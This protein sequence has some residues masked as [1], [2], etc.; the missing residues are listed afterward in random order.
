MS[1]SPI[2][3]SALILLTVSC[4]NISKQKTPIQQTQS[5]DSEYREWSGPGLYWGIYINNEDDYWNH[6][7][8]HYNQER[9]DQ[10]G[11]HYDHERDG[12]QNDHHEGGGGRGGGHR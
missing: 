6:Y 10:H 3:F 1:K 7:N 5:Q 12:R 8:H 9:N 11:D 2:L 4:N